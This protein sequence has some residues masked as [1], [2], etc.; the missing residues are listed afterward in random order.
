M[1]TITTKTQILEDAG[2]AYNFDREKGIDI[3]N[4]GGYYDAP[5]LGGTG[6]KFRWHT[7]GKKNPANTLQHCPVVYQNGVP[8]AAQD[9]VIVNIE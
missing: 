4:P 5:G 2:Y 6:W 1:T 9:P 8:C 7:N 3:W